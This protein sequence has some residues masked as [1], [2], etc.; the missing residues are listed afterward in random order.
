[1]LLRRLCPG[2]KPQAPI[3]HYRPS[4]NR[5]FCEKSDTTHFGY[6]TVPTTEKESLV[7]EVF[8]SVAGKYDLMNDAMSL[9][10]HRLWKDYFLDKL[11]PIPG[12]KLLDVAGGTGDIA[13]R[14]INRIKTSPMFIPKYQP[15]KVTVLDIN[16]SMLQVG[17][18]RAQQQGLG[19]SPTDD[20]AI[21]FIEGNAQKLPIED[22]SMDAYTIAFG[23]RNCTSIPDVLSEAYRVLK[24]G[25]RFLCLEFS[26]VEN[27][28]LSSL[29]DFYS[30]NVIPPM[31]Q[32][33][34]DDFNS[35]QYLVESIRKFPNQ[36][37]FQQMIANAGF[38]LVVYENLSLGVVAIHSGY[39]PP[40]SVPEK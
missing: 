13:F 32:L 11:H 9:G 21:E 26:H 5:F 35:Y 15:S 19:L 36:K 24:P 7:G 39:K 30:F 31:G 34:A 3:H 25:G 1:M 40:M 22:C 38:E 14:F 17:R 16:A 2:F 18:E 10:I 6:K 23:I 33:L 29:Y 37:T 27:S 28:F 20:P 4:Y 8:H 12:T